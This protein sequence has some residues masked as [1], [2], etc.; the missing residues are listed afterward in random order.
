MDRQQ[1]FSLVELAVVLV[2][3]GLL[4]SGMLLPLSAQRDVR[5]LAETQKALGEIREALIGYAIIN[6][7]LPCPMLT[8]MTDPAN[9]NY[10]KAPATC[11]P[12]AQ[13]YL[14]WKTLGVNE[15][16][17][18]GQKRS[19]S[20]DPFNGYWRYRVDDNF[21][22][23]IPFTLASAASQISIKDTAGNTLTEATPNA[24]VAIVFSTGK[25][26]TADLRNGDAT[27]DEYQAGDSSPTF[28]DMLIWIGRPLLLN[29]MISAGKL[30]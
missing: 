28:D 13:G 9:A 7:K 30:P 8:S 18:W 20:S 5:S 11:A 10:G 3:V 1:G 21:A 2:I 22:A 27:L 17:A 14:P 16:D 12:G 15:V 19:A 4:I 24:P 25:N 23:A 29:R 6:G 26:L